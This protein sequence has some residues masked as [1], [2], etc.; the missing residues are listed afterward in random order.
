[1]RIKC[2]HSFINSLSAS[3]QQF[4]WNLMPPVKQGLNTDGL[5]SVI[6]HHG[7]ADARPLNRLLQEESLVI[8]R[9]QRL[10]AHVLFDCENTNPPRAQRQGPPGPGP[11]PSRPRA[12]PDAGGPTRCGAP[13][14]PG[15]HHTQGQQA[16]GPTEP[17][18]HQTQGQT[19]RGAR[20]RG[21]RWLQPVCL[22][23]NGGAV[24]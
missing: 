19:G 1:M 8:C 3:L 11:G 9:L 17:G 2:I 24:G 21:P 23:V 14:G 4:V 18:H 6:K 16:R 13:P 10:L 5:S 20:R 12:P 22:Y 7:P 15:G